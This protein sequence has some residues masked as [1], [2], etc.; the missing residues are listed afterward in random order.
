MNALLGDETLAKEFGQAARRR[1]EQM[2]SGPALGRA[3]A[4]LY[5]DVLSGA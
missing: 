1:Y 2:F 5:R 3:Y 4:Q